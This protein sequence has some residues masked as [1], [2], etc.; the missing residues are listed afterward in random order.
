MARI[1]GARVDARERPAS[2]WVAWCDEQA[3]EGLG[4]AA[5]HLAAGSKWDHAARVG[6][7]MA[8]RW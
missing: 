3:H 8:G 1:K 6:R 5:L 2:W 7:E 4:S